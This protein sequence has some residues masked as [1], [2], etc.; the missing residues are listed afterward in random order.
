MKEMTVKLT[1]SDELLG[2][3]PGNRSL[4]LDYITTKAETVDEEAEAIPV[5][6]QI[7]KGTTVFPRTKD[8][9]PFL[10]DYQIRG[11]FK[12]ACKFLKEVEGSKSSK[13]KAYKKKIDGLIFVRDRENAIELNGDMGI[14]ERPL[15]ASTPQGDRV[16]LS[17]SESV[18]EGS[19]VTFT[20]QC[21]IDS[22]MELVREWLD[23][24]KFHGT[25][26]WRS[27]GKGRY[28]WE[29]IS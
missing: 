15:R 19:K 13:V 10:Y 11:Y 16:A 18:P 7:E 29:E 27:A 22:D 3:L 23:Y 2:T 14:C 26:Q 9:R 17:R 8:G 6:E 28:T 21:L 24:G 12:E 4:F 1:F 20:V 5:D 25:G